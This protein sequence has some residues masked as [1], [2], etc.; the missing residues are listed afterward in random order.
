MVKNLLEGKKGIIF[1][2]LNDRSIAWKVAEKAV[3]QGAQITLSNTAVACRMGEIKELSARLNAPLI[4]ADAT[5]VEDLKNVFSQSMEVFG[6]KVD[7]VLHSIGMSLNVRKKRTYNDL[8]YDFLNKTLDISSISFHKML[9]TAYQMDAINE[10]G[11]IL[12]L[13]YVAAQRTFFG[14]NDMADA[15]ALLES[16]GRSFGYIF[17]C[18]RHVRVNTIYL[19]S[20]ILVR[21]VGKELRIPYGQPFSVVFIQEYLNICS[22]TI[23][24]D[25][26]K[27]I[28]QHS[29]QLF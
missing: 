19:L 23:V 26:F 29:F 8:D 18:E 15:K 25:L 7:F 6:G 16:I 27:P 13:T 28:Y 24:I 14:Y 2:A 20:K 4:A 9:Q 11:S 3:E 10:W 1:G 22:G 5:S 12:A 17:G 21:Y